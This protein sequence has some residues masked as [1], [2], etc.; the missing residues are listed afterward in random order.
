LTRRQLDR[1]GH[2]DTLSLYRELIALRRAELDLA[3]PRLDQVIVD[4]DE[5]RGWMIIDRG[6]P[7][8][9]V[10]FADH[11]TMLP[12]ASSEVLL[13]SGITAVDGAQVELAAH[14]A[15]VLRRS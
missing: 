4:F 10:N 6:S 15:V 1:L 8:V 5:D 2:A 9:V 14:A 13:S 11:P 3:D 7:I 12:V